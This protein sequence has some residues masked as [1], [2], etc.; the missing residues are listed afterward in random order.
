MEI[1]IPLFVC[2]LT[3]DLFEG[4]CIQF[5]SFRAIERYILEGPFCTDAKHHTF[6]SNNYTFLAQILVFHMLH[7]TKS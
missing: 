2:T 6:R 7:Y 4:T 3:S 5:L 1:A